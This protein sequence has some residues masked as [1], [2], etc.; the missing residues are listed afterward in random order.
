MQR[1]TFCHF[2]LETLLP[3]HILLVN[4]SLFI[5]SLLPVHG[6][7]DEYV[8]AQR[9]LTESEIRMLLPLL[10]FPS[11]CQQEVLKASY[12]CAYAFLLQSLPLS[13]VNP[14]WDNLVQRERECLQLAQE[15]K[16]LRTEM[17]GVYN[18]LFG[19]RQKLAPLGLTVRVHRNGYALAPLV[20][21]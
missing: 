6:D 11:C 4:T 16:M 2:E 20:E 18:A 15:K 9:I 14:A 13:K 17:R 19:L 12:D 1:D 21:R 3:G 8:V 10:E 7:T 5:L